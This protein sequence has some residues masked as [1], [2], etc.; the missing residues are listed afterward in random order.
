M[1]FYGLVVLTRVF[2][3]QKAQCTPD[4]TVTSKGIAD[5][6]YCVHNKQQSLNCITNK[7]VPLLFLSLSWDISLSRQANFVS[8]FYPETFDTLYLVVNSEHDLPLFEMKLSF[9]TSAPSPMLCTQSC[10]M[11]CVEWKTLFLCIDNQQ[12]IFF[13]I[14]GVRLGVSVMR[15]KQLSFVYKKA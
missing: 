14:I 10:L 12:N 2:Y 3:R 15:R 13:T 9:S 7:K 11:F 1:S 4:I 6:T 8:F 5:T